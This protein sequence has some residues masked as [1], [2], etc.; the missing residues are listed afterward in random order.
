MDETAIPEQQDSALE[1]KR[2]QAE[3]R[4]LRR[5]LDR[6]A[7][8]NT[9]INGMY[10]SL[11]RV[12]D[13]AEQE[14]RRQMDYNY[15]LLENA[16]DMLA[17]LDTDL[18]FKLGSRSLLD[19][20]GVTYMG[21]LLD[22]PL[23]SIFRDIY[24]DDERLNTA[25]ERVRRVLETREP[26]QYV[27]NLKRGGA[28]YTFS[29]N[30][31]PAINSAGALMGVVAQIHD[32]TEIARMRDAAEAATRAKSAFLAS[33][34]HEI[35]TPLNAI[36]GMTE[37]ATRNCPPE[38]ETTADRLAEIM[39][40]SKH[41]LGLLNDVLDFSKIES[42]K[43][44]LE[45]ASFSLKSAA[46][47]VRDIISSRCTAKGLHLITNVDDL[48]DIS[49]M[50]DELRLKQVLI[51]LLGNAVKFTKNDGE[52]RFTIDIVREG[53]RVDATF[54]VSDDGIGMTE[55]QQSRLFSA[56]VQADAGITKKFGGTGL[57]LVISGRI[58]NEMG[59]NIKVSSELDKGS[60]FEFSLTFDT[61][62]E[63]PDANEQDTSTPDLSGMRMLLTEDVDINRMILTEL[64]EDTHAQIDEAECGER[65][66][67]IFAASEPGHYDLIFMDIQMPG[68]DG[69][70]TTRRIRALDRPDAASVPIVAMTANA[71][72]EDAEQSLASG[73]NAHLTKPIDIDQLMSFLNRLF[74]KNRNGR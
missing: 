16:P 60:T 50:S 30:V 71:F 35:R 7:H 53:G 64:L 5:K 2:L 40:A 8:D 10:E 39:T 48:P 42:G 45:R 32:S 20:L 61:A 68:I 22:T 41:L 46:Q 47:A 13:L 23:F 6:A 31:L 57:G 67:E 19:F 44:D 65:A 27:E 56:F 9:Q 17:I 36:I 66:I 69:Y 25:I 54:S 34:S 52:V 43:L 38:A 51:N 3:V 49:I 62:N 63:V 33:M 24:K 73:M 72:R 14:M 1:I 26:V 11:M 18:K 70:E 28:V 15:L 21:E 12:R 59:G 37:L 55:E 74:A 4:R 29:V 58:V